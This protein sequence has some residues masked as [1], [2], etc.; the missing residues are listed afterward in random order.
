MTIKLTKRPDDQITR[1][2]FQQM[3][4]NEEW[5]TYLNVGEYPLSELKQILVAMC[6]FYLKENSTDE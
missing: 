6:S 3:N 1:C 4:E 2:L 5:E